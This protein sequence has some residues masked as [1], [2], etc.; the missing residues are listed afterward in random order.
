MPS[1]QSMADCQAALTATISLAPR[2]PLPGS[3]LGAASLADEDEDEDEDEGREE[4]RAATP[5]TVEAAVRANQ[6]AAAVEAAREA[7][8]LDEYAKAWAAQ[9]VRL[10]EAA[11]GSALLRRRLNGGLTPKQLELAVRLALCEVTAARPLPSLT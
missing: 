11:A 8:E 3:V 6:A 9:A 5:A 2:T 4:E 1:L 10:G 7:G